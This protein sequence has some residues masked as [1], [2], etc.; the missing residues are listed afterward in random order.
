MSTV[1][2]IESVR[3]RRRSSD[4]YLDCPNPNPEIIRHLQERFPKA[5]VN[6][7]GSIN[8]IA[9]LEHSDWCLG[10]DGDVS[11]YSFYEAG[12]AYYEVVWVELC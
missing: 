3:G 5:I 4:D 8:D 10:G 7:G 11:G 6:I 12:G 2:K 1:T 9:R